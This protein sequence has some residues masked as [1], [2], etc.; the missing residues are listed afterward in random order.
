MAGEPVHAP[1][2]RRI[3]LR[4]RHDDAPSRGNAG[5]SGARGA[6]DAPAVAPHATGS[7]RPRLSEGRRDVVQRIDERAGDIRQLA[8]GDE[9]PERAREGSATACPT[10]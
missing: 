9:L 10:T 6:P 2:Q 7:A 4:I 8:P 3:A 5:Q 1:R